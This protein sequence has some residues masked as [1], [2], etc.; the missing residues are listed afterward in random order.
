MEI[1]VVFSSQE[2]KIVHRLEILTAIGWKVLG[3]SSSPGW[4]SVLLGKEYETD[5]VAGEYVTD[6]R[7]S[8]SDTTFRGP[9]NKKETEDRLIAEWGRSLQ[10]GGID[11]AI[12]PPLPSV[13]PKKSGRPRK[14]S[15]RDK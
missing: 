6:S 10:P 15:V 11:G 8:E 3:Y 4:F 2:D 5:D 14:H 12:I 1:K 7:H 9:G 13:V